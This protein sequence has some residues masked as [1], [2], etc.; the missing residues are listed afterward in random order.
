MS[1]WEIIRKGQGPWTVYWAFGN[2]RALEY[3][4]WSLES[5]EKYVKDANRDGMEI[6]VTESMA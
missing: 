2:A 1:G 4:A 5:A 3:V 6:Y